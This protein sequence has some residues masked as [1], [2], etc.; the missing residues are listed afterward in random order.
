MHPDGYLSTAC[1][2][3]EHDYCKAY[4]GA[5]GTKIPA[6]CKFCGAH[7]RCRHPGCHERVEGSAGF[8]DPPTLN[9]DLDRDERLREAERRKIAGERAAELAARDSGEPSSPSQCLIDVDA[10]DVDVLRAEVRRL[11]GRL[12][13]MHTHY[14]DA[15]T[16]HMVAM[17]RV[18]DVVNA[19]R[20]EGRR[21][22]DNAITWGTSCVGCADRLDGLIAERHAGADEA[23]R[24][25]EA[26]LMAHFDRTRD[27]GVREA[28]AVVRAYIARGLQRYVEPTT[29]AFA[30]P[31]DGDP[32]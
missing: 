21:E 10:A 1:L 11:D 28:A 8:A 31:S 23:A 2:H 7:C 29:T 15:A 19:A 13:W 25:I 18:A 32:L 12:R 5:A 6:Q 4:T 27:P 22:A 20:V 16:V 3:G 17:F 30:G 9:V 26:D 24:N 14:D